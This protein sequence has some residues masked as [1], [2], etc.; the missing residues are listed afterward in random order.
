MSA[1]A[2]R[3]VTAVVLTVRA[4]AGSPSSV[5]PQPTRTP[6]LGPC[7]RTEGKIASRKA[8]RKAN[9]AAAAPLLAAGEAAYFF[10]T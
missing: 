6:S 5:N 2:N 8:Q 3:Q 10:L 4:L 9:Q 1:V 7:G